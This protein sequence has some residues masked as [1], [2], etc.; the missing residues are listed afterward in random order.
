MIVLKLVG[1]RTSSLFK[2]NFSFRLSKVGSTLLLFLLIFFLV[3]STLL[4][5]EV[6]SS[7]FLFYLGTESICYGVFR[8][9]YIY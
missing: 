7:V 4:L 1:W 9:F 8:A 5:L 3:G 2:A 6:V